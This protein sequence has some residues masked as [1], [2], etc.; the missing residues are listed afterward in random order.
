MSENVF[1]PKMKHK[2][3]EKEPGEIRSSVD[4]AG[5]NILS[6]IQYITVALL[7]LL[8]V[9]FM[10]KLFM[11]AGY[12]KVMTVFVA[13]G[14]VVVL[15]SLLML[16]QH[17]MRTVT[18]L[19]LLLFGTF[20]LVTF[21]SSTISGDVQDAVRGSFFEPQSAG[22]WLLTLLVMLLPLSLQSSKLLTI[23][24]IILY[25]LSASV[26]LVYMLL[27]SVFGAEFMSFGA[28][29]SL[30]AT[31]IGGFND[32]A[33]FSGVTIIMAL[34]TLAQLPLKPLAQYALLGVTGLALVQLAIVNF[35]MVWLAVGFFALL[36]FVFQVSK[37]TIFK[38][39]APSNASRSVIVAT[40][41]TASVSLAFLV[42]GD[43]LG[44]KIGEVVQVNY[45]E[46]RPSLEAT[47]N[48]TRAVYDNGDAMLGVGPNRFAD[49]WRLYKDPAINNTLFWDTEFTA[50]GSLVATI[51]ATTGV[52][53]GALFVLFHLG[54]LYAGY[55]M[56]LRHQ[57]RDSYWYYVASLSFTAACFLWG[58]A[59]VYVPGVAML[60][61]AAF[62][63]GLMFAASAALLP[64]SVRTISLASN[65]SRGFA[66]M[67]VAI[68]AIVGTAA[69]LYSVVHQY[70]A[71]LLY[72]EASTEATTLDA[73]DDLL[74]KAIGLYKDDRFLAANAQA[75][76]AEMNAM[77]QTRDLSKEEEQQAL[78]AV[79]ERALDQSERA[80]QLD[81]SN[82]RNH[83]VLAAVYAN[84]A[85]LKVGPALARA[86][87][88]LAD[89][90]HF[91]PT[92]PGYHLMA[93][94]LA[95][96]IG[97]VEKAQSEIDAS[98][99]LKRNY[100]EALYLAAQLD[101][102][103]GDVASAI[104]TTRSI[105]TLEP[106]NPTRYFQLGVLLA[107]NNDL[108]QAIA[109]YRAAIALDTQY[110][111][112]RYLLALAYLNSNRTDEALSQLYV[113]KETNGENQELLG[114]IEQVESGT[115][116]PPTEAEI[117][118]P[119]S[120]VVATD[121]DGELLTPSDIA[122]GLLTPLNTMSTAIETD[123]RADESA[124]AESDATTDVT[125]SVDTE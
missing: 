9:V 63:T 39:D 65:Q 112:A 26:L 106:Q 94:Q 42:A 84:L 34:V 10:P 124:S 100:T 107:A 45:V 4:V 53:G 117:T 67:T 40:A 97:D 17:K 14:V 98:L 22:F 74:T 44:A 6:A 78:L 125:E 110:A 77:M 91:D 95:A 60:L 55:R 52:L 109:A 101:I 27:R 83:A 46:V 5:K 7:G 93:A 99:K 8:P 37:D 16:R 59:Y 11:S 87:S 123:A 72:V 92:N 71:H 86:E 13:L 41:V 75:Y 80:V 113:I 116:V 103:A 56:L 105:I 23:K 111:N 28:F 69:T 18:P 35:F 19:S 88:S 73:F 102:A 48:I 2:E 32:L 68:L 51:F 49:A 20:V 21:A 89:A 31:P 79:A 3:E 12:T 29:S 122:S 76:V 70:Q 96:R 61:L 120:D 104:E 33:M 114:L 58:F 118:P 54:L 25:A 47:I 108:D 38:N 82:P 115:Y 62:F 50:G 85:S 36:M 57:Q 43:Y 24:S 81:Q 64:K 1:I 15:A 90:Q 119:L 66:L 30:T 121:G